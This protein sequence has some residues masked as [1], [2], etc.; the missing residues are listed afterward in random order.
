MIAGR[1]G[2]L[3]THASM[4]GEMFTVAHHPMVRGRYRDFKQAKREADR[5]YAMVYD[6][7]DCRVVYT[8]DGA[9]EAFQTGRAGPIGRM[10]NRIDKAVDRAEAKTHGRGTGYRAPRASW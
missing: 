1:Y 3:P 7:V 5:L 10:R 2:I 8:S 6:L 4:S 9:E